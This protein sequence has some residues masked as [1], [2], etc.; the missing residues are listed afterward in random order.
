MPYGT[1][2][3]DYDQGMEDSMLRRIQWVPPDERDEYEETCCMTTAVGAC[4]SG[5]LWCGCMA[6]VLTTHYLFL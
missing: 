1:F 2:V 4:M 5:L 3:E 6:F